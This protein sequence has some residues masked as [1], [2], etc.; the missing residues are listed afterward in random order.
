MQDF[1]D[2]SNGPAQ[3]NVAPDYLEA[4]ALWRK[5]YDCSL[6]GSG[7]VSQEAVQL[8]LEVYIGV[9]VSKIV[10]NMMISPEK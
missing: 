3:I 9:T 6:S 4:C 1:C 7:E 2:K 8:H 5:S 10:S